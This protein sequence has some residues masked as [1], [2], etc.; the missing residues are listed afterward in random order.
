MP[1]PFPGMDPYLEGRVWPDFHHNLITAIQT[2]LAPQVAP[3]YYVAIEERVTT[4]EVGSDEGTRR[5]DAA[6]IPTGV[7]APSSGGGTAIAVAAEVLAVTVMLPLYDKVREG[8]LEIRDAEHHLVVTAIEV[9]SPTNK[10]HGE[11]R[12]EYEKKRRQVLSLATS[13]I[14]IDLLR[15]GEPMA[16]TPKPASDYR[17]VVSRDSD[18]PNAQLFAFGIR[19]PIPPVPVPLKY[20]EKEAQLALQE[21]LGQVYDRAHYELRVRYRLAPPEPALSP[22]DAAWAADLLR[23]SVSGTE[24]SP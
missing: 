11:G 15:A 16:M 7:P 8:Y 23:A 22:E 2:A 12:R 18:Y 4:I 17:I 19:Q 13:L 5:P 1:S 20:G 21:L 9:L 3:A 14:E 10:V 6:I 24:E